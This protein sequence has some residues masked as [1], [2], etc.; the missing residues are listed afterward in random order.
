M[1][2]PA[3]FMLGKARLT[4]LMS[5]LISV[6]TCAISIGLLLQVYQQGPISYALGGWQA[7]WGIEYRIDIINAYML[8]IVSAMGALVL[9]AAKDT[10]L[11]DIDEHRRPLFYVAYLLCLAGLLGIAATG[12]AFNVFVFLEISSLSM[13]CLIALNK[14]RRALWAAFRYLIV[15]TIGA[16]FILI[17]IGYLY[18]MTGTLN[19]Q[20]LAQRLPAIAD[21]NA[22]ISA[23]A[24]IMVGVGL[25]LALFPLH[26][27]LPNAYTH[28]PNLVTAFL[29][30][31]A[32]KVAVYLVIRFNFFVFSPS[33]AD[34]IQLGNHVLLILG[35]VAVLWA[36]W[37]AI[38]QTDIKRLLAYSSVA[39]IGY[40]VMGIGM[41]SLLS[42]QASLLHLFNHALMKGGL[43]LVLATI[44]LR[45]GSV[46]TSQLRGLAQRMPLTFWAFVIGGLS[47]IGMP[48]TAGFISKWYLV[49][50]AIEQQSWL[51]VAVVL[52][53][54]ALAAI[55]VW[56][57]V[58]VFWFTD[59]NTASNTRHLSQPQVPVTM[60][61]AMWLLIIANVYFGIDTRLPVTLSEMGAQLLSG[62]S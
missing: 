10:A 46:D 15:G 5:L 55:Y 56:K 12:D 58:E 25:K 49:Q 62:A 7:P 52:A 23:Y 16:T 43:F 33:W 1:G 57:V 11:T 6:V 50:A 20:D 17:G 35:S 32:T 8:L 39:Q 30:A 37:I 53:G 61:I 60:S 54:S 42:L 9:L 27:W 47:L 59:K 31:T 14:D 44:A 26:Y 40:M 51:L 45:L 48:A 28:A 22:V 4:W 34:F 41:S 24:F 36:S 13:Y 21:N 2:A 19:M 18:M 38:R 29:A 3:C